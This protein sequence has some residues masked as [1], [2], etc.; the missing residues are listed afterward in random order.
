MSSQWDARHKAVIDTWESYFV[1]LDAFR[2]AVLVKGLGFARAH[3]GRA[4]IVDSS[5][6]KGAFSQDVQTFIGEQ[7]F[8]EFARAGIR[9]FITIKSQSAVTNMTIMTTEI[10]RRAPAAMRGR[11]LA[12]FG[13]G[14]AL[15]MC[16][17][18][19]LV[20]ALLAWTESLLGIV[21]L[22]ALFALVLFAVLRRRRVPA[23]DS[24]G[25]SAL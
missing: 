25:A 20:A 7:L 16:A 19:A 22:I 17:G 2:E 14:A 4:W 23:D 9:Y 10:Q 12:F 15:S 18:A 13:M 24:V 5:K 3:G 8:K 21:V 6:A 11:M 1:T